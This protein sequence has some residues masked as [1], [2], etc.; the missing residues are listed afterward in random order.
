MA[1]SVP[2]M[3]V[4]IND[5]ISP[6]LRAFT[7]IVNR[8]SEKVDENNFRFAW[9]KFKTNEELSTK[10]T[11]VAVAHQKRVNGVDGSLYVGVVAYGMAKEISDS[12]GAF[13]ISHEVSQFDDNLCYEES[14]VSDTTTIMN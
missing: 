7:S 4:A 9:C 10:I 3:D 2:S 11:G 13:L 1:L 8:L 14:V 12:S 6:N 5:C